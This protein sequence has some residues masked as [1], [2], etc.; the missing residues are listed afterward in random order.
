[1]I[2]LIKNY[3]DESRVQ[4]KINVKKLVSLN[5]LINTNKTFINFKELLTRY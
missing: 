4:K 3:S 1:M 2:T 5:E